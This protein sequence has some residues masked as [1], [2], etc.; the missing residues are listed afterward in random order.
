MLFTTYANAPKNAYKIL[1]VKSQG[2]A[3][4]ERISMD[5]RII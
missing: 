3:S 5:A 4:L 2:R 1:F